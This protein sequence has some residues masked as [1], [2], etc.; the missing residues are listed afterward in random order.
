MKGKMRMSKESAVL[1]LP[2]KKRRIITAKESLRA[3]R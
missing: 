1:K 3:R 2:E